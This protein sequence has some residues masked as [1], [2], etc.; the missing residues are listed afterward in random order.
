MGEE[1]LTIDVV[2]GSD[3]V[4]V[5]LIGEIDLSTA[6]LVREAG[7]AATRQ[8]APSIRFDVSRVTFLDLAGLDALLAIRRRA[9]LDG[10]KVHIVGARRSLM[11]VLE[12]TRTDRLF[13]VTREDPG[14]DVA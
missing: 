6:P 11:C 1:Q 9:V 2:P 13:K 14:A 4:T 8:H 7:L 5:R 12:A 3:G 10:G